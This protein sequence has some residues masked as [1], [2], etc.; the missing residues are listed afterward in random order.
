MQQFVEKR[1]QKL[2][3]HVFSNCG[4]EAQGT[5]PAPTLPQTMLPQGDADRPVGLRQR[6]LPEVGAWTAG[7]PCLRRSVLG[8]GLSQKAK[9]AAE[10]RQQA[11]TA[12]EMTR[13]DDWLD[14]LRL[15]FEDTGVS[16]TPR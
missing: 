8:D 1:G 5:V 12:S 7:D 2:L 14:P 9:G 13:K 10:R 6:P 16:P 4:D 3:V 15:C 11:A